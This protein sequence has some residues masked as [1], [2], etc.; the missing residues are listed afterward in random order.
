MLM[1]EAATPAEPTSAFCV[2]FVSCVKTMYRHTKLVDWC[3]CCQQ[4]VTL[5]AG[6]G[7]SDFFGDNNSSQIVHSSDNASSFHNISFSFYD[8]FD[9]RQI[10]APT[11]ETLVRFVGAAISR[12]LQ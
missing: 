10:A 9:G 7:S 6:S 5:T 1:C 8:T 11:F 4:G 12:P 3:Q 2:F